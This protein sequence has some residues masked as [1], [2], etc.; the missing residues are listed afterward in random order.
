MD[1]FEAH[2]KGLPLVAETEHGGARLIAEFFDLKA[3][4]PVSGIVFADTGWPNATSNPFH[5][6]EGE[7]SEDDDGWL[8]GSVRIRIA[9]EGEPLYANWHAW[10]AYRAGEGKEFD[11]DRC[12]SEILRADL[13]EHA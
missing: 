13:F 2:R 6:L 1:L 7:I 10:L 4:M 8:V 5:I 9:A 3:R 11:R 12:L